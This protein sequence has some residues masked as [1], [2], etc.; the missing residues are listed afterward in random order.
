M[1]YIPLASQAPRLAF[2]V[3]SPKLARCLVSNVIRIRSL[4]KLRELVSRDC[5]LLATVV[6]VQAPTLS[7][8][9]IAVTDS[10]LAQVPCSI[11]LAAC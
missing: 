10:R 9:V 6:V 4:A 2:V 5:L 3:W 11:L 1:N 7:E 8:R